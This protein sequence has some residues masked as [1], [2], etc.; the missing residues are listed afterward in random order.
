VGR[1]E[2]IRDLNRYL[3]RSAL[4]IATDHARS[5]HRWDRIAKTL[6]SQHE[7][8]TP[9]A[10]E[11]ADARERLTWLSQAVTELPPRDHEAFVH[12]IV[13]GMPFEE[14][15]R[16]MRISSRMAK[17]YVARTL[18]YLRNGLDGSGRRSGNNP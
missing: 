9:S 8:S 16:A 2:E 14:V 1:A 7:R 6:S 11:V 5:R 10:E 12:R 4:N 17:I 3:W 18:V 15:G 13:Q